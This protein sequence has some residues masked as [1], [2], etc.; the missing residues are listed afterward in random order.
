[1]KIG[2]KF[3]K[4]RLDNNKTQ[5][6][7]AEIIGTSQSVYGRYER[8]KLEIP[9]NLLVKLADYFEVS[10]DDIFERDTKNFR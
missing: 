8:G 9:N 7:I 3:K 4:L 10:L 2:E 5:K 1:M 6:E